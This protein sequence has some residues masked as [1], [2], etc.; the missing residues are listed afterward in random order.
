[1]QKENA[2]LYNQLRD[3]PNHGF[4][5]DEGKVDGE[6]R[7]DATRAKVGLRE[8][9][10][11]PSSRSTDTKA[12]IIDVLTETQEEEHGIVNGIAIDTVFAEENKGVAACVLFLDDTILLLE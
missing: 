11:V 4:E 2:H 1:M 7:S 5:A 6:L 12:N 3:H 9:L 10:P 8:E